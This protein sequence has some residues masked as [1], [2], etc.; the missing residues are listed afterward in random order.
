MINVPLM[1]NHQI[2]LE[3]LIRLIRIVDQQNKVVDFQSKIFLT[4]DIV[5]DVNIDFGY[6]LMREE[7]I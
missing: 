6:L 3:A 1:C 4:G 2:L 7:K 5:D